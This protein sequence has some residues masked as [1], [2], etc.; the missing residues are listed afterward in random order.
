MQW[1]NGSQG[2]PWAAARPAPASMSASDNTARVRFALDTGMV[3]L[4]GGGSPGA[5]AKV[6]AASVPGGMP[7][8]GALPAPDA[9]HARD[10]SSPASTAASGPAPGAP[11]RPYTRSEEH[12]PEPP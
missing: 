4:L 11:A 10:G 5:A 1:K 12:T 3:L 2:L 7:R 6:I 9:V 8:P